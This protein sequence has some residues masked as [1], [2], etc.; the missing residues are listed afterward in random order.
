MEP[1]RPNN[2][3]TEMTAPDLG[4][5]A[6]RNSMTEV[7]I[8]ETIDVIKSGMKPESKRIPVT[9]DGTLRYYAVERR[10]LGILNTKYGKFWELNS[11]SMITGRRIQSLLNLT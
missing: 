3:L 9:E 2:M 6:K 1:I 8:S 4:E 10:G 5:L 7:E 11:Q